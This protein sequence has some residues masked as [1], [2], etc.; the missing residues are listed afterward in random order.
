MRKIFVLIVSLLPSMALADNILMYKSTL[1]T[2][3]SAATCAATRYTGWL[4]VPTSR[5]VALQ[6]LYNSD[7]TPGASAVTMTCQT[8][9]DSSVANG[10][11]YDVHI[12][13]DSGTVGT[14]TSTVHTWS[15]AVS[16]DENW[17]WTVA[18]LPEN[19]VNCAFSCGDVND[20]LTVKDKRIS[21]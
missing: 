20:L 18:N 2:D 15:N 11:G 12:L 16:D 9:D 7:G 5:S 3:I 19:F 10:A 4:Q 8:S 21:P 1:T 14:S 17:T 6:I 13:S